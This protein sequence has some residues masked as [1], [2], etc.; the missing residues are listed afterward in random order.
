MRINFT[1]ALAL[2]AGFLGG[3]ASRYW[4]PTPAYA[5]APSTPPAEVRA[6]KFVLVDENGIARGVFGFES[7]GSPVIEISNGNNGH[8]HVFTTRWYYEGP[9][10][11][12]HDYPSLPHKT[13]LLP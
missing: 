9:G 13:T 12:V 2:T 1:L 10:L 8:I 3:L 5:Q 11:V 4:S 7:N 6:Q